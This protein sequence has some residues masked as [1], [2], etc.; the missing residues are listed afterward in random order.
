MARFCYEGYVMD[1]YCIDRGTLLDNPSLSTLSNPDVHSVHCLVDVASCVNSPFELLEIEPN[2][3]GIHC[4]AYTLSSTAKSETI[5]IA[6]EIG[7]CSTCSSSGIQ[8]AGEKLLEA[9]QSDDTSVQLLLCGEARG[10]KERSDE[11]LR[12]ILFQRH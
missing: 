10:R 9:K 2:D 4:R 3:E 11:A 8:A 12:T 6:R 1:K 5:A 7:V